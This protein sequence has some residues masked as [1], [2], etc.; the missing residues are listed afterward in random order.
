VV[1]PRYLRY[2]LDDRLSQALGSPQTDSDKDETSF[3]RRF[4]QTF[5]HESES[6]ENERL[7][8]P[9]EPMMLSGSMALTVLGRSS[10]FSWP[11]PLSSRSRRRHSSSWSVGRNATPREPWRLVIWGREQ[12]FRSES[13][14]QDK[15]CLSLQVVLVLRHVDN[16]DR[17]ASSV[18]LMILENPVDSSSKDRQLNGRGPSEETA[19]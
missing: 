13:L 2:C 6:K 10:M 19:R 16:N 3:I 17:C 15:R 5:A 18:G 4:Y 8:L 12:F 11:V 1:P 14:I 7:L 9:V